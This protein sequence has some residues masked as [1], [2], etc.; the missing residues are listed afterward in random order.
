MQTER[1]IIE[2]M[3]IGTG[4]I[5][6]DVTKNRRF[7]RAARTEFDYCTMMDPGAQQ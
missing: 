7:Y 1:G 5:D 4:A 6:L 2:L 3:S